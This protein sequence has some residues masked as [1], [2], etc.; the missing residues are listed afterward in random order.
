MTAI[1]RAL[2]KNPQ[3]LLLDEATSALDTAS[4]RIVQK[5]L[6]VASQNR[7]TIVIAHRLST[8]RHADLI[9]VMD[10]G[11]LI[12]QGTHESL[13]ALGGTYHSL[14]EK[15][16]IAT[17]EKGAGAVDDVPEVEMFNVP[18]Q[19]ALI[20]KP[21]GQV[22]IQVGDG[23]GLLQMPDAATM[24]AAANARRAQEKKNNK[25][26]KK[27]QDRGFTLEVVKRMRPHWH[28]LGVGVVGACIAGAVRLINLSI[29]S[30][31]TNHYYRLH[32][33]LHTYSE[34]KL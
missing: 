16:R 4:E 12:E 7:T 19:A 21:A 20:N 31:C 30:F 11:I 18:N 24:T 2:I 14:V 28:L 27:N 34:R 3:I 15:Q 5:A 32:L 17:K 22:T 8:I 9:V 10:K 6:D 23:N 1:A 25:K 33:S 26:L 13:Y 29:S